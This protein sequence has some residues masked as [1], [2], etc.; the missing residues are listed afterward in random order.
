MNK[1]YVIDTSALIEDPT[2]IY[3]FDNS[4]IVVPYVV[5]EELDKL[6]KYQGDVAKNARAAIRMLDEIFSLSE[7]DNISFGVNSRIKVDFDFE[8]NLLEDMDYGDNEIICCA[9]KIQKL[10]NKQVTIVTGDINLR[11]KAKAFGMAATSYAKNITF[12]DLFDH[13]THSSDYNLGLEVQTKGTAEDYLDLDTNSFII[14]TD[15][16]DKNY[17]LARKM[18]NGKLK[19]LKEL[20]PWGLS[21]R[22]KDQACLIELIM[23]KSVELVSALGIA[24]SGKT[25]CALACGLELVLNMKAFDKLIIFRPVQ[26]VGQD[27]GFLPGTEDEKMAPYFSAIM[28]SMEILLGSRNPTAWKREL[29]MFIN[30]GKIELDL[31]TFAR[32]RSIPNALIIVD[33]AQNF[34][35]HEMKT[36][37]TRV[38]KDTKVVLTGD[39]NQIDSRNLNLINNGLTKV[40]KFFKGSKLFGNVTLMKGERSRLAT[41][42]AR[43]LE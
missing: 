29:E 24:G 35:E 32:G 19:L 25:L 10:S 12:L 26:V 1:I 16:V 13:M 14:F 22:N 3:S 31:I 36:L 11:L 38:G 15:N 28:D 42:A 40:I 9:F 39:A 2:L 18:A 33:E 23:D 5:L 21:P 30:K 34:S 43:V 41:E 7:D 17:A 27:I 4:Q 6:K 37:L 8:E 20:K